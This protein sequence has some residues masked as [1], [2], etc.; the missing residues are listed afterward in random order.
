MRLTIAAQWL[1]S[2]ADRTNNRMITDVYV[3]NF[4][5]I[6]DE[7]VELGA[8]TVLVG[9]NGAG[10]SSFVD[11]LRFVR[12]AL[13][14]G[15]E[16]AIVMR[17]G[18]G[19]LRRWA[20]TRPYDIEVQ[21]RIRHHYVT[22]TYG[23]TIASGREGDFRVKH[24]FGEVARNPG[25]KLERFERRGKEWIELS[26]TRKG[27]ATGR[28]LDHNTLA[29]PSIGI[30]SPSFVR[31]RNLL[32]EMTFYTIF[33]NT[34]REPQK[35]ASSKRL[36]DHGENLATVVKSLRS[37]NR[38]RDLVAILNKVVG[39]IKD[40]KV[41][42]VGG[43]LVTQL[44]HEM[45]DQQEAWFDLSQESD[46]TLRLL[47][48]LVALYQRLP[49][50]FVAVEEPEL[51]LHPG[52]VGVLADVLREAAASKQLLITTQSPDLIARFLAKEL[53]VVE[54]IAGGVTTI[55][56]VSEQQT[57]AINKQ[58]FSAGDLL[59]IEGLRGAVRQ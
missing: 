54:R 41:E 10:K 4:R 32:R 51:T 8:V 55:S 28:A 12:D 16:D 47:G 49:V 17:H 18:I 15:I 14:V 25:D 35:P 2:R 3:K 48:L 29:L 26:G 11:V 40:I 24:E 5:G 30:F 56:P 13:M 23:F 1:L 9:R 21:L 57:E 34:L 33:P 43:F 37:R 46:G 58:L 39:G 20:P 53:R 44:S 45:N 19:A 36:S 42:Q 38:H 6:G 7:T 27:A 50:S 59:R 52:A 31:M 22:G